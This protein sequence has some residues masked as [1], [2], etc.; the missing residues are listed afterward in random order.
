MNCIKC[1]AMIETDS[2]FCGQCGESIQHVA[3]KVKRSGKTNYSYFAPARNLSNVPLVGMFEENE[4]R[5]EKKGKPEDKMKTPFFAQAKGLSNVPQ[6]NRRSKI[7]LTSREIQL[8]KTKKQYDG[9][10]KRHS[11]NRWGVVGTCLLMFVVTLA[12]ISVV[13]RP[14]KADIQESVNK[15]IEQVFASAEEDNYIARVLQKKVSV[16][17]DN[18]TWGRK[19]FSANCTVYSIDLQKEIQRYLGSIDSQSVGTYQEIMGQL[20]RSLMDAEQLKAQISIPLSRHGNTYVPEYTEEFM[21]ACSGYLPANFESFCE[22]FGEIK[23]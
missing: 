6:D 21:I 22:F 10:R 18:I 12:A 8:S 5:A 16:H 23:E 13:P 4:K 2:R 14:K 17:I 7:E 1:G 20:E 19:G 9:A 15:T 11:K 3:K